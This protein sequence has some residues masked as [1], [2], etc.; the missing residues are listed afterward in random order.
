MV[1]FK[2]ANNKENIDTQSK[3]SKRYIIVV[4]ALVFLLL[5]WHGL[6]NYLSHKT[7]Q[8]MFMEQSVNGAIAELSVILAQQKYAASVFSNEHLS[9]IQYIANNPDDDE[10]IES[11]RQHVAVHFP[12]YFAITIADHKGEPLLANFDLTVNEICQRAIKEFAVSGVTHDIFIHPHVDAYHFDVMAPWN[13]AD[14]SGNKGVFFISI[15][16][17]EIVRVLK[18]AERLGHKL[19]LLKNDIDGLIEISSTGARIDMEKIGGDFFLSDRQ[20]RQIGYSKQVDGT[21]WN[22]VDIPD[23]DFL[24]GKR[25][26]IILQ[27]VLVFSGVC[28]ISFVFLNLIRKEEKNRSLS[29]QQLKNVKEQLEQTLV[30][31]GVAT[32]EYNIFSKSFIWSQHSENIF[33]AELPKTLE[34]YLGFVHEEYKDK[35]QSFISDCIRTGRPYHLEHKIISEKSDDYWIEITG[36]LIHDKKMCGVT[37]VGLIQEVTDRK[38]A[39]QNH[40]AFELRQKDTLL[41]EV[42]HRIKNN[43]QGVISLLYHHKSSH[44]LNESV[45][46]NAISQLYSVSLIHGINGESPNEKINILNLVNKIS[47]AAFNVKGIKFEDCLPMSRQFVIQADDNNAVAI[48]LIINELIFNAIKH[49]PDIYV[50]EINVEV[51]AVNRGVSIEITNKGHNLPDSFNFQDGLGLG[52]GLSLVKSLLPK[53]GAVISI[54]Q[55]QNRVTSQ[56][57]LTNP[58]LDEQYESEKY[59]ELESA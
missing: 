33:H 54:I 5:V 45:I 19:I 2:V 4:L 46:E 29:E 59:A 48:A 11:L 15:K 28:I 49:T 30:F 57:I 9:L 32:W 34:Q 36:S 12:D 14:S 53:Q 47:C 39:E 31:S 3:N 20:I 50:K 35:F 26:G 16:P 22:L 55:K 13:Y 18:N 21:R 58:L 42:H 56:L 1:W 17:T 6:S 41:R 10:K 40:I 25:N 24:D 7:H 51:H 37:I 27:I 23:Q 43:L 44:D 38:I 8:Q 52:T